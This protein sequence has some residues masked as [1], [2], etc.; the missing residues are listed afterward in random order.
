MDAC[1]SFACRVTAHHIEK[2][3]EAASWVI[4]IDVQ[5]ERRETRRRDKAISI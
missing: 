1:S 2:K 4:G 3:I 5:E